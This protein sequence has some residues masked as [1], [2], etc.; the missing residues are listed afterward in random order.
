MKTL[1]RWSL[2]SLVAS[3][4]LLLASPPV[5]GQSDSKPKDP[6]AV[7]DAI[8]DHFKEVPAEYD[9]HRGGG[10]YGETI[11]RTL[12]T[13]TQKSRE[14]ALLDQAEAAGL[15]KKMPD[16]V[17][18]LGHNV[19]VHDPM[20]AVA[21]LR[22]LHAPGAPFDDRIQDFV[23]PE[24]VAAGEFGERLAVAETESTDP[25]R[26]AF[27]SEYLQ[28]Y[29]LYESSRDG[30][31]KAVRGDLEPAT[32]AALV[33]ALSSIGSPDSLPYL[34]ELLAGEKDDE[35]LAAAIFAFTAIAGF[36]GGADL[37]KALTAGRKSAD[38]L[39]G[40]RDWLRNSTRADLKHGA[41]VSND[42]A[43][44]ERFH[45]LPDS[46]TMRWIGKEG[47]FEERTLAHPKP[48]NPGRKRELFGRLEDSKGFGLEAV[49]G[50]LFLSLEPDDETALLRIRQVS[51]F[52]PSAQS[53]ARE[54]AIE[55]LVRTVRRGK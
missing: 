1:L 35:V 18:R 23:V 22:A 19:V 28:H 32:R 37:A 26:R 31:T 47:L 13:L 38:E 20:S 25:A 3:A 16:E 24:T 46:E 54:T 53:E 14:V 12:P 43:F 50:A 44:A 33:R 8:R 11:G 29:A 30:I 40:A 51:Y 21:Y 45:D 52:S 48:L 27:W 2:S 4:G 36:D 7:L 15:F 6:D 42:A 41:T 49:K 39:A 10:N 17:L 5:L 55:I 34:R 9:R